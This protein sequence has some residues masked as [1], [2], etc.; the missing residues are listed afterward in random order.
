MRGQDLPL[1]PD[2]RSRSCKARLL[3]AVANGPLSSRRVQVFKTFQVFL[4]GIIAATLWLRTQ[5]HPISVADANKYVLHS[6]MTS[7]SDAAHML[8]WPAVR[9]HCKG[10]RTAEGCEGL[11]CIICVNA[12]QQHAGRWFCLASSNQ[13]S[14]CHLP[15]VP[16]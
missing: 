1:A 10:V 2:A 7:R 16:V 11:W 5:T 9:M 13:G 12:G 3:L 8:V 6:V 4:M 15:G 14:S